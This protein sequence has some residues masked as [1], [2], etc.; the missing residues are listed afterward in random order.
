MKALFFLLLSTLGFLSVDS[1]GCSNEN[2]NQLCLSK[3]VVNCYTCEHLVPIKDVL[4]PVCVPLFHHN[5]GILE[6]YPV[7]KWNCTIYRPELNTDIKN[8]IT[9]LETENEMIENFCKLD[10]FVSD[11][12]GDEDKNGFCMIANYINDI[13]QNDEK[14]EE[15]EKDD[16]SFDLKQVSLQ[17]YESPWGPISEC[18][19]FFYIKICTNELAKFCFDCRK[20]IGKELFTQKP[21]YSYYCSPFYKDD[22]EKEAVN[23]LSKEKYEC[24]RWYNPNYKYKTSSLSVQNVETERLFFPACTGP[25]CSKEG[26]QYIGDHFGKTWCGMGSCKEHGTRVFC[27]YPTNCGKKNL[28]SITQF[29]EHDFQILGCGSEKF[30][31]LLNRDCRRLV[32][33][34]DDCNQDLTCL[35]NLVMDPTVYENN[36]FL[37]LV[38]CMVP[39]IPMPR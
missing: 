25:I 16:E 13:C 30:K 31:C 19:Q 5:L 8:E 24:K 34:L 4:N 21:R 22:D 17:K 12:C 27:T 6:N 29:E 23:W 39:S 2:M 10:N 37:D 11:I 36:R 28:D 9:E 33:R 1:Y 18:N 38:K 15:D 20:F 26:W 32:K 14:D 35:F 3:F 7:D